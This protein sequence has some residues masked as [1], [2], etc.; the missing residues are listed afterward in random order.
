MTTISIRELH[1]KTGQWVRRAADE[2][3]VVT[4]R[5]KPVATLKPPPEEVS[6]GG[7]PEKN[8]W[9]DWYERRTPEFRALM[10]KAGRGTPS[11]VII[12]ED[13]DRGLDW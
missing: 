8:I 10:K 13:R 1:Q 7:K 6:E 4:D 5:G 2:D 12:S 3:I 11:E 9:D